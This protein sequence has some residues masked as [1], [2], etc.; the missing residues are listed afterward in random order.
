MKCKQEQKKQGGGVQQTWCHLKVELQKR[1]T[2]Q[3]HPKLG[4]QQTNV[5]VTKGE[6]GCISLHF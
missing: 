3:H 5:C 2:S 6:G 4:R 1:R